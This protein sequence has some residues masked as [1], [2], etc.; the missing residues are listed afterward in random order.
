MLVGTEKGTKRVVAG[1]GEAGDIGQELT[2]EVK[3]D[4]EE[5]ERN[6]ADNTVGL[7]DRGLL[8]EVDEHRVLRELSSYGEVSKSLRS[9]MEQGRILSDW[10]IEHA[11]LC[12]AVRR[13]AESGPGE[14]QTFLRLRNEFRC[15]DIYDYSCA[16]GVS[17]WIEVRTQVQLETGL[18]RMEVWDSAASGGDPESSGTA[19]CSRPAPDEEPRLRSI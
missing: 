6:Q 12:R 3:D 9:G 19:A 15:C 7:G 2:A 18:E 8:L 13:T 4:Q 11:P 17:V 10:A 16:R 1:N 5:V 14:Q